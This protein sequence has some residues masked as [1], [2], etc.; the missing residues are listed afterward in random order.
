MLGRGAL[1]DPRLPRR[2]AGVLGLAPCPP[3]GEAAL[4]FDW[5]PPLRRLGELTAAL[6]PSNV[7]AVV[8]RLKQW[9]KIASSYGDFKAFD[10]V[11]RALTVEELLAGLADGP[12][13]QITHR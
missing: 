4:P 12:R 1:A 9:L 11:K 8:L 7:D 6:D 10:T 13:P 5:Q 3:E 2:I